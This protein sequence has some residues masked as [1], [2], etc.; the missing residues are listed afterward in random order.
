MALGH[1]FWN[2]AHSVWDVDAF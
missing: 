2:N 1:W